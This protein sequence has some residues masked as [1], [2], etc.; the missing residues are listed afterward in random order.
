[1]IPCSPLMTISFASSVSTVWASAGEEESDKTG[2]RQ[3]HAIR[4]CQTTQ[5]TFNSEKLFFLLKNPL[6]LG[7][8]FPYAG[9]WT[10]QET[11]RQNAR[12]TV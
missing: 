5:T 12:L 8:D 7:F 10:A 1:M 3:Q 2:T 9:A 11:S 6:I 4:D